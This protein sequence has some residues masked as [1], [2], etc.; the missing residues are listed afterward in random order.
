LA[1]KPFDAPA[2][3]LFSRSLRWWRRR[4]GARAGLEV[5]L[6]LSRLLSRAYH[7]TPTG[8]DRVELAYALAL[9]EQ[10]PDRLSF[11]AIHP[12]G[13]YYGRLD[14]GAVRQFLAHTNALWQHPQGVPR[15]IAQRAAFRH[16]LALRPRP[17][18]PADH[19]RVYLQTSPHHLDQPALV[20]A[21]LRAEGA[22]MAVMV[23]DV[24]PITHPE[25]ARPGER[26]RHLAR[27]ATVDR[28]ATGILANSQATLDAVRGRHLAERPGRQWRVAHLGWSPDHRGDGSADAG[29]RPAGPYFVCVGTIEPRKNHLLLLQ[30][31]RRL[32]EEHGAAAPR[33]LMIG[34]RGWEN[35][36][37][38]DILDRG[39]VIGGHVQEVPFASDPLMWELI[40]GAR[41]LLLPSFAEGFGMPVVEA[42]AAGTPVLCSDLPA[43]REAGGGV[44]DYLDPLDGLGWMAAITDYAGVDSARRRAQLARLADW[45]P[46]Q[47]R[48]HVDVALDLARAIA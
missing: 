22:R 26:E 39:T 19:A 30:I 38:V 14:T 10:P 46:T 45:R 9:L 15:P 36:N 23:H 47:W 11:S 18:P 43:L 21:L 24:I 31:W 3:M 37:V 32:V 8:I 6:D 2:K 20:E 35:E 40:R 44:P 1:L 28:F 13:G 41:A 12:A 7:S 16:L 25:Y 5:V 17:I 34:R 27:M 4:E 48:E 33:L 29:V 42:L